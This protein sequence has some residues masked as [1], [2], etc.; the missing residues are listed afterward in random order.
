MDSEMLLKNVKKN[1]ILFFFKNL[2]IFLSY[3]FAILM[4]AA[5]ILKFIEPLWGLA[6]MIF[7]S[8]VI[9][10]VY[11]NLKTKKVKF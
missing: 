4:S 11:F 8:T 2:S 1:N 3:I 7:I 5:L 10:G 6:I 9:L